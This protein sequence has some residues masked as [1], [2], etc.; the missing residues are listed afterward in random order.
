MVFD[1]RFHEKFWPEWGPPRKERVRAASSKI[2]KKSFWINQRAFLLAMA[3]KNIA[4]P[5]VEEGKKKINYGEP[6]EPRRSV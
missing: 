1:K 5:N 4:E 6:L 2:L 3:R